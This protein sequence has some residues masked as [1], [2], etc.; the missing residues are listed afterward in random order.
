MQCE[1]L[2]EFG[3]MSSQL[4][5]DLQVHVNLL[6]I[7]QLG[8]GAKPSS[9]GKAVNDLLTLM[10]IKLHDFMFSFYGICICLR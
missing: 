6:L 10:E 8:K 2:V 1:T 4:K 9:K 5:C 7:L 3:S